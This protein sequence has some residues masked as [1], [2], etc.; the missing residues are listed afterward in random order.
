MIHILIFMSS[1]YNTLIIFYSKIM[2]YW[3]LGMWILIFLWINFLIL[4]SD[5]KKKIIPNI[6]LLWLLWIAVCFHAYNWYFWESL[7]LWWIFSPF[8]TL[9]VGFWLFYFWIWSAGDAKYLFVLSFF[10]PHQNLLIFFG[11]L[12]ILTWMYFLLYYIWFYFKKPKNLWINIKNDLLAWWNTYIWG[13][14]ASVKKIF[15]QIIQSLLFFLTIFV[16][17]RLIRFYVFHD[18]IIHNPEASKIYSLFHEN[19]G[20]FF[21]G[22]LGVILSVFLAIKWIFWKIQS[23]IQKYA[24]KKSGSIS[25]FFWGIW[26]LCLTLFMMYEYQ[27]NAQILLQELKTI[28]TFWILFIIFIKIFLYSLK[29]CF[30][31]QEQY[32]IP[33]DQLKEWDMVDTSVLVNLFWNQFCLGSN[34]PEGVLFPNPKDFFKQLNTPLSKDES[35]FLKKIFWIV[36]DYQ[37]KK[38]PSFIAF[39][40]I[41]CVKSFAFAGF[42]FWSFLM[43]VIFW[44]D[45]LSFIWNSIFH[46]FIQ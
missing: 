36:N 43:S 16:F 2:Q 45:L 46:F 28:F 4:K 40:T 32:S 37:S 5:F 31:L 7:S 34:N 39:T 3:I 6:L 35:E 13:N 44:W 26:V 14:Q 9:F 27:K 8:L 42:I 38:D 20:W 30:I 12:W 11:N 1:C 24:P 22:I 15:F 29:I 17:Y 21:L 19:E 10:L 25:A 18:F 23:F 33:I 41:Q